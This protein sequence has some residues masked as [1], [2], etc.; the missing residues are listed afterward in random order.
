MKLIVII[1]DLH[2]GSSIGLCSEKGMTLDDGGIYK[3]SKIQAGIYKCFQRF[4]EMAKAVKAETKILVINGDLVDG[5]HHNTV[6]LASNNIQT[7]EA[8]AIGILKPVA[9]FFDRVYVV[10][11][12]EAHTGPGAA[13]DERIAQAIGAQQTEDGLYSFWQLWLNCDDITLNIAHNIGTAS[14][15]AYESSAPMRE[16]VA[17]IVEA[18]QWHTALPDVV[19]RS[20]RHRY[21]KVAI[22]SAD[23][24][25]QIAITPGWQMRTPFVERVNRFSIPQIGGLLCEIEDKKCRII[26]VLYPLKVIQPIKI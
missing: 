19:I 8:A 13:S 22:P 6:A 16:L 21:I 4:V 15:A 3:P 12:T 11:G 25:I 5:D 24:E 17:A 10:R 23:G 9:A 14:S 20:H 26:P 7:Q 2:V 1:S 18:G